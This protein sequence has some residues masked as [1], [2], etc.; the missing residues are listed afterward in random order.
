MIDTS[1]TDSSTWMTRIPELILQNH[2]PNEV[3]DDPEFESDDEIL[4]IRALLKAMVSVELLSKNGQ[5]RVMKYFAARYSR[6]IGG[7]FHWS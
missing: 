5:S 4:A 2:Q 6:D 7:M 3:A 1:K